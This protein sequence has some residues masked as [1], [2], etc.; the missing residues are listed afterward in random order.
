MGRRTLRALYSATLWL[1][2]ACAG[3]P[4]TSGNPGFS[5]AIRQSSLMGPAEGPSPVPG[6]IFTSEQPVASTLEADFH[7]L[8][9]DRDQESE[10]RPARLVMVDAGGPEITIPLQVRTRGNF[11]LRGHVCSFPPLR[12]NFSTEG[13]RGTVFEGYDKLKLVGHCRNRDDYEQNVLEEYLAYRIYNFLTEVSFRV[14]LVLITYHDTAGEEDT[15]SRLGFLIEDEETMAHRVEGVSM[16]ATRASPANF[17]QQQAGLMYVFQYLI[18][19]TDW[20]IRRFHNVKLVRIGRDYYPV[21]YDFDFSGLVDAPYAGPNP[22]VGNRIM[23]VTERLFWGVCSE[24]IDYRAIFARFNEEREGIEELIQTQP[25]LTD[26]NARKAW[27]FLESFYE[28]INSDP[29][30]DRRILRECRGPP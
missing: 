10:E 11:R 1:T 26:S 25:G 24:E 23:N 4:G 18:G 13:A 29:Q 16:E 6:K 9:K 21:P 20:T 27:D 12:L 2:L 15:V 19:N 3:A 7:Q 28:V 5:E 22:V 30:A 17:V 8:R 14:Q